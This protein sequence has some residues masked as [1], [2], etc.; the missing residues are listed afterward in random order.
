MHLRQLRSIPIP[1]NSP[2]SLARVRTSASCE[3]TQSLPAPTYTGDI[4]GPFLRIVTPTGL[5]YI[6]ADR[7]V[8]LRTTAVRLDGYLQRWL[9]KLEFVPLVSGGNLGWDRQT[10]GETCFPDPRIGQLMRDGKAVYYAYDCK[11][12]YCER[13]TVDDLQHCLSV[14]DSLYQASRL[15]PLCGTGFSGAAGSSQ[16]VR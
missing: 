5:L 3:L 15:Q 1:Q 12:E 11:G 7:A 16:E 14:R 13:Y 8:N 2:R 10:M 6:R 4:V 9:S